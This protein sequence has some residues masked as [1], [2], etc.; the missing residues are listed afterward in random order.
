VINPG[1]SVSGELS[2]GAAPL[3]VRVRGLVKTYAGVPV[4]RDVDLDIRHGEIFALLGPNGAGKTTT[5][6]IFEGFRTRDSGEV[7]VLGYDPGAQQIGLKRRIG[8]VLQ[9]NGVD[10]YLTVEETIG[11]YASFYPHPRPVDEVIMLVGLSE[12]RRDRAIKLSGGQQRRLDVAVA[13]VGDPDLL[14]LDEP[15]TG[16]DP[17][18]R[19]DAWEVIL[20]LAKLGKTVLLTTHYMDEAQYLADTVAVIAAGRIVASGPPTT[21]G[22]REVAEARIRY[23]PAP[24][25]SPPAHLM[26][27]VDAEGFSE[28]F[29]NDTTKALFELTQWAIGCGVELDGLEVVRPSLEDVYLELTASSDDHLE[30]E[31]AAREA[32]LR[33]EPN[34]VPAQH[35]PRAPLTSRVATVLAL[36]VS[37]V[38]YVN[39]AFW[40]NPASAFFTF[41]FP[42]MFL[43]IFTSLAGNFKVPIGARTVASSTFYVAS[44]GAFAVITACFNNI[45]VA[46]TF[47]REAGI[48]KRIRGTPLPSASFLGAR[49]IHAMLVGVVLVMIT[50]AFGR[51][52]YSV[53]I[54]TGA[55]LLRFAVMLVVG[56]ASFCALGL[57][58]TALIPNAD[59]SAVIVNAIILPLLFL[60]G[61]F[62]PFGKTTPDWILWIARIFPIKHFVDGMQ[63]G[64]LDTQFSWTDVLIVAGWGVAGLVLATRFF[65][66]EPAS[67]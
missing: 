7:S 66:W 11:M 12:K 45:A 21:L 27:P 41:A 60:S 2:E 32:A 46:I 10:Q 58:T 15:T 37:Q 31:P 65:S 61:I 5:V 63:A 16:F 44:M 22:H 40:R 18:A 3:A 57:A 9:S 39:K 8:M 51:A 24:G 20:N 29:T 38:R 1:V 4:V 53:E 36:T 13:L 30:A 64:F 56:A 48:L 23:R 55:T 43:V 33:P 59:S 34:P 26:G 50:A 17:S 49:I 62:I 19:R 47:Q 52:F 42:L 25:L 67:G 35:A 28:F 54:P 6:E 14:F